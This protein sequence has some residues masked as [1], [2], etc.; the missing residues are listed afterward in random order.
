MS[1]EPYFFSVCRTSYSGMMSP[2]ALI[3][4][5]SRNFRA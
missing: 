2:G 4:E 1:G 3:L 5:K